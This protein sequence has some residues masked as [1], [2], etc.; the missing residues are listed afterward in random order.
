MTTE[1]PIPLVRVTRRDVAIAAALFLIAFWQN[2]SDVPRTP[3]H[4]DE[5]RW[6]NRAHYLRDVLDPFGPTWDDGYLSRGQ[7]PL[8]SYLMGIGLLLQGRDLETNGVWDF[9]QDEAWNVARGNMSDP[10]DLEAGRRINAVVGAVTVVAL[11]LLVARLTNRIGATVA[12][13]FLAIHP[14][15]IALSSQAL[16]D[17]LTAFLVVLAALAAAAL[18]D[19]PTWRRAVL[20][21][22][23]L[24]LGGATKLSPLLVTMPLAGLGFVL[25]V[26]N[27]CRGGRGR[28]G[29]SSLSPS[30]RSTPVASLAWKL[31]ALPLIAFAAFVLV[32]PYL[33]PDPIGRTRNLFAFRVEEMA[34]QGR[35]WPEVAVENPVDALGRVGETLSEEYSVS[36]RVAARLAR[37]LGREW[38]PAGIDLPFAIVGGEILLALAIWRGPGSRWALVGVVLGAQAALVVAGMRSDYARYHLPVLMAAAACVGVL[39]G[40]VWVVL[41]CLAIPDHALARLPP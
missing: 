20:L 26:V 38:R 6:L 15:M 10:A 27:R 30:P 32:N 9:S 7:P 4:P 16:S 18:A 3:F 29:D 39:A 35:R 11:Y 22:V 24:G 28:R 25:I 19:R 21:G 33:W 41:A 12:A 23:L 1:P 17:A 14:L 37:G 5:T 2:L 34:D 40:Q 8:G 13:L 31:L 36:G